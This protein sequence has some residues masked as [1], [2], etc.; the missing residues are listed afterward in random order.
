MAK[1]A[2]PFD[3]FWDRPLAELLQQLQATPVG[4]NSTEAQQR[5]QQHG[6]NSLTGESRFATLIGFLRSFANPLVIILIVASSVSVVMGDPVSGLIIIAMVLLSVLLNFYMEFQA[7]HAVEEIRKQVATTA[8]V[9]RDGTEQELPVADLVPGDIIRLNAGDL[10]PADCRLL[11]VRD[12]HV[13]ESALTGESLPVEKI[14]DDLPT[15]KHSA[16]EARNSVFLSTA[17]QTGMGTAVVV[18]TGRD[19]ALGEIAQR[20]AARPPETEFGRGIRQFGLMITRVIMALVLFVLL[21]NVVLHRPLLESFLFSVAL[22]VGM[23]PEMMPLII[24]VTLAQGARRMAKK[25]VLV[26]QLSAIEDF[27]SVTILCS[28]KTGTLTEGEIVLDRHVDVDGKDDD[29]VLRLVYLNSYFEAGIKSPLDE[30]VLKHERPLIVEYE[31]LDE[32]PFDFS[33]KRLSV[34]VRRGEEIQLVTKGEAESIFGICQSV[35]VDGATQ[36]FDAARQ[37]KAAETFQKLSADGYRVLGVAA[38]RVEQAASYAPAAEKEM[39]LAGF[40]AFLDPPKEGIHTV[41]EA[42]KQNGVSIVVMTGDNQYVT[43]KVARDVGLPAERIVTGGQVDT[44]DDAALAYQAENSAI[45]ARVS[46]EQK[47]RVIL[48]LKARGHVVGYMGDGINDAPSL[49]TA[50]VGISVMNGVDV[51]KDSAK[52]ILLEKDLAVLNEGV[53]E[54][55]RCFANIMKYIVMG[56]SSNFGNMFSMAGA[57]LFLPFLPMLPTQVLLNNFL[58]DISQISIPSDNVDPALLRQPKRWRIDFIRQFMTIIGPISSVYDFLTF[59][60]L[61]WGFQAYANAPL[62]R[63]AWFV[64]SLATQTLVVF[65]IRT[66]GNPLKSRPGRPLLIAV[67]SIVAIAVA[68]PYTPLGKLLSFIPLPLP[69]LGAIAVLAVTYLLVVQVVKTWFYRKHA[70][71]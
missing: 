54:G 49:H 41:L 62:F 36:P 58:Y 16:V 56:T 23:T 47:N 13:R 68:L 6:A 29:N 18:C 30:A 31:K 61:L 7:R 57:S 55:R 2:T 71:L 26:K 24:T 70:L 46:P 52:I 22:A 65:V 33:R 17:V 19:T 48:A 45:F 39:T 69:L 38:R 64:E 63:T 35:T 21:V 12:L 53:V 59:G 44:M 5:L 15:G 42:L 43:Q 3:G 37:A 66:A 8:A 51:A 1:E 34:V 27:G 25:K 32:I 11:D 4:L 10:V 60:L 50:D 9:L 20:L 14:A 67:F 40:A 28:D